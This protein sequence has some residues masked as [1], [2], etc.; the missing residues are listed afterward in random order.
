[1][2]LLYNAIIMHYLARVM[3]IN[4]NVVRVIRIYGTVTVLFVID[5]QLIIQL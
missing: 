1:M 3:P 5:N 4:F 2:G